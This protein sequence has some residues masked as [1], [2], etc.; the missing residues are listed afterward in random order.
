[1]IFIILSSSFAQSWTARLVQLFLLRWRCCSVHI[2]WAPLSSWSHQ[3]RRN[4]VLFAS[5][6]HLFLD[7]SEFSFVL[8]LNRP[9]RKAK[10]VK[11]SLTHFVPQFSQIRS[12]WRV[13]L[14]SFHLSFFLCCN[15]QHRWKLVL[16]V[17]LN[18]IC[19]DRVVSDSKDFVFCNI[20][21]QSL[22]VKYFFD[23][24]F[25]VM[26]ISFWVIKTT[27]FSSCKKHCWILSASWSV[28]SELRFLK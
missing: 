11:I 19:C 16:F 1:M 13:A 6:F 8:W 15:F 27:I 5:F 20:W 24:Y 21:F 12:G 14:N 7:I 26:T 3:S 28:L 25:C 9:L 17:F 18:W 2:E 4:V 10:L 23:H 22:S